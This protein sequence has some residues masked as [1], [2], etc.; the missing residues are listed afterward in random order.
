MTH[1]QEDYLLVASETENPCFAYD[2]NREL[3]R[4][5]V[6]ET[7]GGTMSIIQIPGSLDF[8]ATQAFYPGFNAKECRIIRGFYQ[9]NGQW[10]IEEVA[11]FPY[12]HRFDLIQD[13]DGKILFVGCT[14]AN[15]K[16]YVE[17]WTD[18]GKIFVASFNP[19]SSK[20]EG[21]K[22]LELR[23]KKNHGYYGRAEKGYSLIT[24]VEGIY[25]LHYPA[26]SQSGQWELE[27]LFSEE[28][29]D[30]VQYDMDGDGQIE[31]CIIQGF[32]G[33]RFR[34]LNEDFTK[35]LFHYPEPTP[36]GHA[37]WSGELLG[38]PTYLFGW[39][40]GAKHFVAFT[41][42][43]GQWVEQMIDK[44]VASSNCLA[45]VKDGDSYIFSANNGLN[46]VALYK[47]KEEADV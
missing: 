10:S 9:G 4:S 19:I 41:Y 43:D 7:V 34:I 32:H 3:K 15:S 14:I 11:T 36:F 6:W 37:I 1:D 27:Q 45:F 18:D 26:Y 39:R 40:A 2:L 17:D 22:E 12:L 38:R 16:A 35:E 24:G 13:A 47:L 31:N 20:L 5:L 23:L 28:T 25:K 29:S 8:L 44:G 42:Q 33:D 46:Q 21:M 30:I